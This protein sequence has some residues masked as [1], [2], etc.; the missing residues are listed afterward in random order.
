MSSNVTQQTVDR[1]DKLDQRFANLERLV[2][3]LAE[4]TENARR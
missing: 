2:E 4:K 3:K 1:V